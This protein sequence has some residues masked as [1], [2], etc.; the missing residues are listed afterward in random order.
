MIII[1]LN[2]IESSKTRIYDSK[3]VSCP[4]FET[5]QNSD[6]DRILNQ[7]FQQLLTFMTS[8]SFPAFKALGFRSYISDLNYT[9]V[10][11]QHRK[12]LYT[13]AHPE[14]H[15]IPSIPST[16]R[17]GGFKPFYGNLNQLRKTT[18]DHLRPSETIRDH[19]R[20]SET[21]EYH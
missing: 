18:Q 16:Y 4:Y 11:Y 10:S 13:P 7:A 21:I 19:P 14:I 1:C 17:F 5:L 20:P 12:V 6:A 9:D 15:P 2:Q 8:F 3:A